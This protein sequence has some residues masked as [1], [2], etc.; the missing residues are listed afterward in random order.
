VVLIKALFGF[1]RDP[2]GRHRV[3]TPTVLQMEAV[4]C[5]AAALGIILGYH[6]RVVPLE[7]LRRECGVSRDGSQ[8]S[9]VL[10]AARRYGVVAKGFK[11]DIDALLKQR[12]P[13]IVFWNFNHFVVVEGFHKD[14]VYLN[15]PGTGPRSVS[16]QEFN[17][18]YTGL[19][20]TLEPGP[21][22][23]KGGSKPSLLGSLKDR[24]KGSAAALLYCILAGLLL[25]LPGL[26][27]PIFAQI[28]VDSVLVQA[29]TDWLRPLVFGMLLTAVLRAVLLSLQLKYLRR[30]RIKLGLVLSSRFM[31]HVLRLPVSFYA[32]RYAGEIGSRMTLN[33]KV[34]DVLSGRLIRTAID[35]VMIVF[36]A[37]VMFEYDALLASI[38][39]AFAFM[40]LLA[41]QWISRRRVDASLRCGQEFGRVSGVSIAGLKNIETLKA[42]GLESDFFARWAGY[43]AKA[44]NAQ[45]DLGATNQKLEILPTLL[46]SLS[47]MLIIVLGGLRVLNG[48]FSI[49]MLVAFQS[50]M[51]SFLQ[52]VV[53]LMNLGG[54]IQELR[55]DLTRLDDVLRAPPDRFEEKGTIEALASALPRLTGSLELRNIVFGYNRIAPPLIAD[56]SLSIKPGQRVAIVGASGSGKSTV[57][58][59]V[60]GLYEPWGG[61]ILFDGK[62]RAQIPRAVL[63]TSIALVEQ[64]F[65]LFE[66]SVRSNLALW[67]ST[68]TER[69]M[70]QACK[71]AEIHDAVIYLP[72]GYDALLIEG[73]NNLSGGQ[74]QRLEIARALVNNPS[75]LVLDEA[76]SALDG[77]TEALID[78]NLRLRGC[79]CLIIAHRVS[80][81]RDCDE[82]IVLDQGKVV[83]RGSH[84]ELL[85]VAGLYSQ[86]I[87]GEQER[88]QS[89]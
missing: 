26:A 9:S 11:K 25:V 7:E 55:S 50:L 54:T 1:L 12:C 20:L 44:T 86:L 45:Q 2:L 39:I 33:D 5:G 75:I 60:C 74:R 61:E 34:A 77:E 88:L 59:L 80:T 35:V 41:L 47:S 24:L 14:K 71:D 17:E 32:Q 4:E 23:K 78:R 73:G 38:G 42:S 67:D 16:L 43:F 84:Q 64:D 36:I 52:P 79:S 57:A 65:F 3:R 53:N 81:I 15:D 8:A 48:S 27:I 22:F 63:T 66:G 72:G 56:F 37:V 31:W 68:V 19:L 49:G 62:P 6:G 69:H 10:R 83:E 58:K 28:F 40:N 89:I 70:V 21:D 29:M 76:M 46:F 18:S 85:L 30:L 51:Q 82:I 13:Y 87:S